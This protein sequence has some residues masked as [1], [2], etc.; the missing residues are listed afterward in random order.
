MMHETG[1]R[2]LIR[3]VQLQ[4]IQFEKALIPILAYHKDHYF[5]IYFRA[6][7]GKEKCDAIVKE[8]QYLLWCR[9][10]L[11]HK[12]SIYN[13]ENCTCGKEMEFAGPLWIGTLGNLEL[14]KKMVN[15]NPFTE[16]QKFLE[17]IKEELMI[18]RVGFYDLHE[19][20]RTIKID[21]PKLNLVLQEINGVHSHTC[22]TGIKTT[23]G[24]ENVLLVLKTISKPNH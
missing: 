10:C 6:D 11:E 12:T 19:L 14:V 3:K 22:P 4:G 17:L 24:R 23:S 9:A 18:S 15:N 7:K 13:K 20:A 21:P 16:E 1:L 2:I 5:R 8:H